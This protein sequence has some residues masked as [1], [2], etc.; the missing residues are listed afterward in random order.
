MQNNYIIGVLGKKGSGKTH[1]V[2]SCLAAIDRYIV[3]DTLHEYPGAVFENYASV[4]CFLDEMRDNHFAIVYRPL[5]DDDLEK[6]FT[7]INDINNYTLVVEEID[8]YCDPQNI[9]PEIDNLTRY[10]RHYGRSL[11]WVSRNPYEV[12]RFLT[13]Q[14]DLLITFVQSEPRDLDY[15]KRYSFD[16]DIQ[17]LKQYEYSM[18]GDIQLFTTIF[19]KNST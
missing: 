15:F 9:H 1:L 13:R 10:G 5:S 3:V 18:W 2:T 6:F 4:V 11:I 12:N 17:N 8:F 7:I 14:S 19:K 16:K